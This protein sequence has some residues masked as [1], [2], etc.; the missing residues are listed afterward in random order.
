VPS[1]TGVVAERLSLN[2]IPPFLMALT[3]VLI[4]AYLFSLRRAEGAGEAAGGPR[5]DVPPG[6]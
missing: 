3:V 5:P 4:A 2:A 6:E 1:L